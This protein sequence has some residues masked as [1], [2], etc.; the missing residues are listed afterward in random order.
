M[1]KLRMKN[2]ECE[3]ELFGQENDPPVLFLIDA[4]GL[5]PA[6]RELAMEV[7]DLGYR[8]L[9]PN[10]YWRIGPVPTIANLPQKLTLESFKNIYPEL[11]A[12][13]AT[14]SPENQVEDGRVYLDFFP[15][16][17][18]VV[19]FCFGARM[20]LRLAGTLTQKVNFAASIHG[21]K[22][23]QN[24]DVVGNIKCPVYL[25]HAQDDASNSKEHIRILDE[26]LDRYKI[27]H[28]TQVLRAH[29]GFSM[30]DTPAYSAEARAQIMLKIDQ[31]LK[32][33]R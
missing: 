10:I 32:R 28:E 14:L 26:A 2:G 15:G 16:K 3:V 33:S 8:V 18:S 29:H 24:M 1:L 11:N 30:P 21:G 5:R 7:A 9:V 31:W 17:V 12:S 22:L 25:G 4:P 20:A 13:I 6:S 23:V 27:Q 19:G